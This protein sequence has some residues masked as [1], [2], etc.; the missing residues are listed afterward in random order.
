M[1]SEVLPVE[2]WRKVVRFTDEASGLDAIIAVHDATL[3]PGC[4]GCRIYPYPSFEAGLEDVKNL[5]RG[6]T[7][8]NALGGIP[9]GGGKA[10]IFADPKKD[11]TPEMLKAFARAVDSLEGLYYTAEDSGV[12][13]ADLALI[14]S[15]TNYAAGMETKGVGGNPSPFTARG[16]WRGMQAA[17]RHKFGADSLD[18][19][20]VSILG[21]GAVGMEL[22][23]LIHEE[24]GKLVVAD[25]NAEA[26]KEAV[27][28][29]GAETATP[30]DAPGVDVD[31]FAP[32]ALG[33]AI[34]E[35]T[36]AQLKAKIVAGA[37]NNQLKTPDMDQRLKDMG[38]LYCPDY[39]INGAGVI[40]VGLEITGEWTTS[41][42]TKR[43][44][45]IGVLLSDIFKRAEAED[46]PTG[47]VADKMALEV[48]ARGPKTAQIKAAE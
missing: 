5:S 8:K 45:H 36:I 22:A 44:D 10:V 11:K 47:A 39:V 1:K 14:R 37:A 23:R 21:V 20:T 30:E 35:V 38:V 43:I 18:G 34:N 25:V 31:I 16:V 19:L 32:C 46:L 33:G 26:V 24:G 42:M 6:M 4:G 29:F 3:G 2:G 48:I 15:V 41:E 40:S 13:E 9:F 27:A 28:R 7:Y 17:A 12:T